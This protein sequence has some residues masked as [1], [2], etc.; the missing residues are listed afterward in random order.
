M[1]WALGYTLLPG[2][3]GGTGTWAFGVSGDG[4]VVVGEA[5]DAS[6]NP[7]AVYWTS[8]GGL[9]DLGIF[10][11]GQQLAVSQATNNDGSVIV[12]Y[13]TD[14][15][16]NEIGF[17]WTQAT[18]MVSLGLSFG[19]THSYGNAVSADGSVVAGYTDP[20][21]QGS[22]QAFRWTQAGGFVILPSL[23]PA[24]P[25]DDCGGWGISADGAVV[26]GNSSS[27]A[28]S[29]YHPVRWPNTTT[30]EDLYSDPTISPGPVPVGAY[31][32]SSDGSVVVGQARFSGNGRA[33]RWTEAAGMVDLAP[34]SVGWGVTN[35]GATVVGA[36][37]V[38]AT[39][40]ELP[41]IWT[42]ADGFSF[43]PEIDVPHNNYGAGA[44]SGDGSTIAGSVP[45]NQSTLTPGQQGCYWTLADGHVH[46][47]ET[48]AT[49]GSYASAMRASDDGSIIVGYVFDAGD[50]RNKPA[51]WTN[52]ALTVLAAS[53]PA[54]VFAYDVSGDGSTILA[55]GSGGSVYW[56]AGGTVAHTLP[57]IPGDD[58]PTGAGVQE[59]QTAH[60]GSRI[61]STDGSKIIGTSLHNNFPSPSTATG[62]VW[63]N[64]VLT[65]S[66]PNSNTPGGVFLTGCSS[67][68]I[69]TIAGWTFDGSF[70]TP[71]IWLGGTV[72]HNLSGGA[73]QVFSCDESGAVVCLQDNTYVDNLSSVSGGFY[74]VA[75]TRGTPGGYSGIQAICFAAQDNLLAAGSAQSAGHGHAIRW[76]GTTPTPLGELAG[77]VTSLV[78]AMSGDG[79]IVVGSFELTGGQEQ[80]VYWDGGGTPHLL[81]NPFPAAQAA[82]THVSRDG[83]IGVGF[84]T[85]P[86]PI[87]TAFVYG[88][89]APT[90]PPDVTITVHR[91][92][93]QRGRRVILTHG[94][95]SGGTV[96][97]QFRIL[98]MPDHGALK[99]G[100]Q[101][102]GVNDTFTQ[103]QVDSGDLAYTEN[104][105]D[106]ILDGFTF[107]VEAIE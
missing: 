92:T 79:S 55:T 12:G 88:L 8:D 22:D 42:V 33:F 2:L 54:M 105:D 73:Q 68:G 99:R 25:Y 65:T 11:G 67:D 90:P 20:A 50:S 49:A 91:A 21:P 28:F 14:V 39:S 89:V 56:T 53:T 47:L 27:D 102:L 24:H 106:V 85:V 43:L 103:A 83:T 82:V 76:N 23:D 94:N 58:I 29:G 17:I 93:C 19:S 78:S 38:P 7:H 4:R 51:M 77:W 16:W 100:D 48:P 46:Y 96:N 61:M 74:G 52:G 64:G 69:S 26:V 60:S 57:I 98:T 66:L 63:T 15:G 41:F 62:V 40:F 18:G 31:A 6:N 35:D 101:T 95:I 3:P 72:Q 81:D 44:I 59:P 37:N 71:C 80:P 5:D 45:I 36:A 84:V 10:P 87:T 75:H 34:N 70:Y 86:S 9:V 13:A 1:A 30:I 107:S 97:D 104:G 32:A